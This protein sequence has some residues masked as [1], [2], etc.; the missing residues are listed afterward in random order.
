MRRE[1]RQEEE[2]EEEEEEEPERY[3]I[4]AFEKSR[5]QKRFGRNDALVDWPKNEKEWRKMKGETS[6]F[7]MHKEKLE[8]CLV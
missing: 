8:N 4:K 6:D 1:E 5:A 7:I 2:E 3:E